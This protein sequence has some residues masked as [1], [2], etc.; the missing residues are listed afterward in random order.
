MMYIMKSVFWISFES[1][2]HVSSIIAFRQ[3]IS[4]LPAHFIYMF[5]S[6]SRPQYQQGIEN[7]GICCNASDQQVPLSNSNQAQGEVNGGKRT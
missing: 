2:Q 4:F 7:L 1:K 5:V 3:P 6:S